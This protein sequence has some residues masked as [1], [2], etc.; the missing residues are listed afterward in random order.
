MVTA[1]IQYIMYT[2]Y[3]TV[4]QVC[5][6]LTMKGKNVFFS[7]KGRGIGLCSYKTP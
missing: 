5:E 3:V 2:D 7:K 6:V 1:H 4:W